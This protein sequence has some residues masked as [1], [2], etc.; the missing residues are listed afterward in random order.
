MNVLDRGPF[1]ER[2]RGAA[3]ETVKTVNLTF[4]HRSTPLKQG[5]NEMDFYNRISPGLAGTIT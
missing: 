1:K 4:A 2:L 3:E 5:V